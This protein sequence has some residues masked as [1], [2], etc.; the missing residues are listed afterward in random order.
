MHEH[1]VPPNARAE[2]DDAPAPDKLSLP[3]F[4]APPAVQEVPLYASV[5]AVP[6]LPPNAKA[7]FCVPAPTKPPLAVIK[8]PPPDHE[9]PLYA[10]VQVK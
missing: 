1:I 7:E 4:N 10:S 9:V 2:F 6:G 5:Q 3:V 8:A